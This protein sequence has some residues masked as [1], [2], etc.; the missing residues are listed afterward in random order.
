MFIDFL[1]KIFGRTKE[2]EPKKNLFILHLLY[3]YF[4]FNVAIREHV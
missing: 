1:F 4:I 2:K 3:L